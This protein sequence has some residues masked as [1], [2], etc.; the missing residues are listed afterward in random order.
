MKIWVLKDSES[1]ESGA[2]SMNSSSGDISLSREEVSV[3]HQSLELLIAGLWQLTEGQAVTTKA[4]LML[5]PDF[6]S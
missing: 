5:I 6:N 1:Q 4:L 3:T 2:P